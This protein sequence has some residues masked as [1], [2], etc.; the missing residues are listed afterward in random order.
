MKSHFCCLAALHNCKD[1]E[2]LPWDTRVKIVMGAAQGFAFLHTRDSNVICKDVKS[3]NILLDKLILS[4][5]EP[6]PKNWPSMKSKPN[7]N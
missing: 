3:S 7:S 6:Q 1:A 5:L 2:P 4:C